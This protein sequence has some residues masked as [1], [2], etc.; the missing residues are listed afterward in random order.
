MENLD[1]IILTTI[2]VILFMV[3]ILATFKEMQEIAKNPLDTGKERGP[4][5][6][7]IEFVGRI[8]SEKNI[9]LSEKKELL[10]IIKK[11]IDE[12]EISDNKTSSK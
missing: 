4:R 6:D 7:M 8:F 9:E 10:N 12:I 1:L 11:K 3:F 2:V 5:A